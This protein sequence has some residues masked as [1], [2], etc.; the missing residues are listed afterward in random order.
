MEGKA[1]AIKAYDAGMVK[2]C[3][4]STFCC[5]GKKIRKKAF[6]DREWLKVKDAKD[7]EVIMWENL[8]VSKCQRFLRILLV[9]FVTIILIAGTFYVTILSK[10]EE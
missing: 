8:N 1:R 2:R 4:L 3:C 5:E 10:E 7:P 6:L 9:A